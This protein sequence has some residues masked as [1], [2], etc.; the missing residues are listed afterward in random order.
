MYNNGI[1]SKENLEEFKKFCKEMSEK[2]CRNIKP[3]FENWI[4]WKDRYKK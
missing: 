3:T 2:T 4:V 1:E